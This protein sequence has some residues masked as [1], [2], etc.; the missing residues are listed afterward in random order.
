MLKNALLIVF[1]GISLL[2]ISVFKAKAED[3]SKIQDEVIIKVGDERI[4]YGEV[5]RAFQKNMNRKN[6][7]LLKLS[8]DSL[9]KFIELFANYKLKVMDA[10]DNNLQNDKSVLKEFNSQRRL[11]A[12][13]FLYE[14]NVLD[15]YVKKEL[16]RR[17]TEKVMSIILVSL[18][19]GEMTINKEP[20]RAK[21]D[22]AL[23]RVLAG[24]D[25]AKVCTEYTLDENIKKSGGLVKMFITSCDKVQRP[26]EDALYSLNVGEVYP[27]LIETNFGYIIVKLEKSE[28]RVLVKARHILLQKRN[29]EDTLRINRKADSLLTILKNK[30]QSFERIA[31]ENSDDTQSAIYGGYIG[32]YYSRAT[33]M[34]GNGS[35]LVD[36]FVD[37]LFALKDGQMSGKVNSEFGIHIIKRDSTININKEEEKEEIIKNYKRLY[38]DEDKVTYLN[39]LMQSQGYKID[40]LNFKKLIEKLDTSKT[41]LD[42]TFAKLQSDEI[43]SFVIISRQDKKWTIGDLVNFSLNNDNRLKGLATNYEGLTKAMNKMVE[44]NVIDFAT[45]DLEHQEPEFAKLSKDFYEGILLFRV[46]NE[47]VWEKMKFDTTLAQKYYQDH[48]NNYQTDYSYDISE[49]FMLNDSSAKIIYEKAKNGEN[50][51]NLA[52]DNTQRPGGREKAGKIG[53][54]SARKSRYANL[55]QGGK[56]QKG[57]ILEPQHFEG[58]TVVIKINDVIL[59]RQKTFEEAIPDFSVDVQNIVRQNLL[60]AWLNK[61]RQKHQVKIEWEKIEN[62]VKNF[63]IQTGSSANKKQKK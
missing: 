42:P 14:K 22:S 45:S 30:K 38:Y 15:P 46:E 39:N 59:P 44:S 10:K 7:P 32:N 37:A 11:L 55:F 13:S 31:E 57:D 58:A 50:F 33:G 41:N 51:D 4:T 49:I 25:F 36:E 54:V 61:V 12:E 53:V 28:P 43:S 1:V 27:K 52:M 24:E 62:L 29:E 35:R 63:N 2:G 16:E 34:Q 56:Y 20:Y 3:L 6:E 47:N 21:A 60:D 26:I 17:E 8:K 9:Q 40:E 23:R 48:K 18:P 19:Q 5:Q